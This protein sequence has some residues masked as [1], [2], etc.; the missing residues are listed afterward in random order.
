MNVL[1]TL[2]TAGTDSGPFN[3]YS[4]IDNYTVPFQT[5]VAKSVLVSGYTSTL[6][7]NNTSIIRIKST[8]VCTNYLDLTISGTTTTTTSSSTTTTTTTVSPNCK[9]YSIYSNGVGVASGTYLSCEGISSSYS[10]AGPGTVDAITICAIEN[11]VVPNTNGDVFVGGNC[12]ATSSTN[13]VGSV[14]GYVDTRVAA[15]CK[16]TNLG[17]LTGYVISKANSS[18]MITSSQNNGLGSGSGGFLYEE[19]S[20][21]ING[22][23]VLKTLNTSGSGSTYVGVDVIS[24]D[25]VFVK[26]G[27]PSKRIQSLDYPVKNISVS[28]LT[29]T[30]STNLRVIV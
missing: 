26:A 12:S 5:G 9:N 20:Y 11:S 4:N 27:H 25:L 1:I 17:D 13:I 14:Q 8:G 10:F 28:D 3:L 23:I 29:V 19:A 24:F 21:T 6:V 22:S 2:T 16:L 18:F 7:P 30:Y 15:G